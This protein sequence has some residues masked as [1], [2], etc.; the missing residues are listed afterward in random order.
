M[1][2]RSVEVTDFQALCLTIIDEMTDT[3]EPLTITRS[4]KPIATLA[5]ASTYNRGSPIGALRG[6]VLRFDNP[7]APVSKT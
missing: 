3:R 2:S 1:T 4:G 5:P 7:T 6:S